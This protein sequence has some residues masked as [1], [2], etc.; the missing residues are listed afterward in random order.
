MTDK[1]EAPLSGQAAII[2]GSARNI[3]REIA[4]ALAAD[5]AA[6]VVNAIQD[7][8]AADAVAKEIE[9]TGGRDLTQIA[10][11]AGG[12][13]GHAETHEETPTAQV[14]ALQHILNQ[15]DFNLALCRVRFGHRV[16]RFANFA[17]IFG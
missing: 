9:A 6:I 7:R 10:G 14:V 17:Q 15:C 12:P 11:I 5:G 4:L 8:D 16:A 13:L 1:V 2:T 3:G